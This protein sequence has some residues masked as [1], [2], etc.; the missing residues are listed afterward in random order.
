MNEICDLGTTDLV[1]TT[2]TGS[3]ASAQ[4][5]KGHLRVDTHNKIIIYSVR[6]QEVIHNT[7]QCKDLGAGPSLSRVLSIF[8]RDGLL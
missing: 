3:S 6:T 1:M 4:W 7:V 5:S 8:K 2:T